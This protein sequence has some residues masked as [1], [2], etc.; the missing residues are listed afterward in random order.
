MS[1]AANGTAEGSGAHYN[2][3]P[4]KKSKKNKNK[5][6]SKDKLKGKCKNCKNPNEKK[7]GKKFVLY[8]PDKSKKDKKTAGKADKFQDEDQDDDR[9]YAKGSYY[10]VYANRL[11]LNQQGTLF[12][13]GAEHHI[14]DSIENLDPGIFQPANL[15]SVNTAEELQKLL[16]YSRR[17]LICATDDE[18][19]TFTLE[20]NKIQVFPKCGINI[21]GAR[22][23]LGEGRISIIDRNL[24]VDIKERP[25]F[26][27]NK[28]MIIIKA[29][30]TYAFPAVT[31]ASKKTSIRLWHRRFGHLGLEN[32]NPRNNQNS[33][34]EIGSSPKSDPE[35][36][37]KEKPDVPEGNLDDGIEDLPDMPQ[38]EEEVQPQPRPRGRPK[39]SK[40]KIHIP[41][42][43][44]HKKTR[45]STN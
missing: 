39:G 13:T 31:P 35:I 4:D 44:F 27:F 6:K 14:V 7:T 9:A 19:R 2:G 15:P 11:P 42:P 22:D 37:V 16:G 43:Q 5:S 41:N 23:L 8:N 24:V 33:G 29:H 26:R 17:T 20:L 38:E 36:D 21:F 18:D 40:N 28:K 1:P 25:L 3:K 12:D 45:Q 34:N 32:Q 30:R 10:C